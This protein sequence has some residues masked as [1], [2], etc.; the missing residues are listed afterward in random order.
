M[1]LEARQERLQGLD[2][3]RPKIIQVQTIQI[4]DPHQLRAGIKRKN[5]LGAALATAGDM[6]R[7]LI[8]IRDQ[9]RFATLYAGPT[10]TLSSGYQSAGHRPLK[11]SKNQG[12][13]VGS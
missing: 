2:V 9:N 13:I 3:L 12:A 4:Q 7:K 10:N 5:Q 11:R 6:T 8:D 1:T